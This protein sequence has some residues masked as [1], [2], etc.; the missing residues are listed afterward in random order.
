LGFA[1]QT[2]MLNPTYAYI[3]EMRTDASA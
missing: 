2:T 3:L 1:W